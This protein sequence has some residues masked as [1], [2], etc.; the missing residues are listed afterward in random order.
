MN[1]ACKPLVDRINAAVDSSD[2]RIAIMEVCG[3]H[4]VSLFRSGV[5]SV[6]P[7]GLKMV[8]GPGCPVCVTTQGYLDVACGLAGRED[9]IVATYGDM[10]RVPGTDTSLARQKALGARVEVVY[11]AREALKIAAANPTSETVF[12]AVGF[13]TTSP[14]TAATVMEADRAGV[15]N[16]SILGGHKYVIPALEALC[17][18]GRTGISGFMLP[19]HVSAILGTEAYRPVVERFGVPCVVTGFEPRG[20]LEGI[21]R[22]AEYVARG[23]ARLDNAYPAVVR[24]SGNETALAWLAEVFVP[25]DEEWRALGMIEKSGLALRGEYRRFDAREKLGVQIV[26]GGEPE[27]CRCGEVIQ[28]LIDP[29]E[30]G[31]FGAGC[32]PEGPVGPCMVSSEGACAAWHKYGGAG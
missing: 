16:F 31:L 32:T 3:T 10:V 7:R 18:N 19:G 24:S 28:G 13:E 1:E 11:S 26:P 4:T 17:S 6:L 15:T 29:P 8:S 30:C 27:G 21:A 9:V 20:M 12:L 22:V 5:R 2:G 23:E 25:C 14:A